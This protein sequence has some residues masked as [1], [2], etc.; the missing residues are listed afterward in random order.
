M[1]YACLQCS[2]LRI[3]DSRL[4]RVVT[5]KRSCSDRNDGSLDVTK[6]EVF[7]KLEP[8]TFMGSFD[9]VA[10]AAF[11]FGL[12]I[13]VRPESWSKSSSKQSPRKR[14]WLLE[15]GG[16]CFASVLLLAAIVSHEMYMLG[17]PQIPMLLSSTF[18]EQWNCWAATG[19]IVSATLINWLLG[20]EKTSAAAVINQ[21]SLSKPDSKTSLDLE[22]GSILG[23][24]SLSYIR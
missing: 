4:A 8:C 18:Y 3:P 12:W 21:I 1:G 23:K 10:I 5:K 24:P 14:V 22:W 19:M 9:I 15:A 16:L 2:N 11:S 6:N 20:T 13:C 7:A 17:G